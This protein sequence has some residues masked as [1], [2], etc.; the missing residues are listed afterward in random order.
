[1]LVACEARFIETLAAY[2]ECQTAVDLIGE[3][4]AIERELP[5]WRVIKDP[6]MRDAALAKISEVRDLRSKAA[7]DA[8]LA[9][10]GQQRGLP[11]SKL[12]EAIA[13]MISNWAG[14]T[15]FLVEPRA[16]VSNNAAERAM[17]GPVVGR[18]NQLIGKMRGSN[19]GRTRA[20]TVSQFTLKMLSGV[21]TLIVTLQLSPQP[22][23]ELRI[24]RAAEG[25]VGGCR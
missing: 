23:A 3:L 13:Y 10:V 17:R 8:L 21:S 18:K 7:T 11:G 15:H 24:P 6:R 1:M 12:R 14:L 4:F 16:P 19:A 25:P 2:P 22:C 20:R 9:W 5:D